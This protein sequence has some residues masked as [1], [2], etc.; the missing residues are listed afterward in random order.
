[1]NIIIKKTFFRIVSLLNIC[2]IV[3]LL[4]SN[5]APY[6][7][8]ATWWPV[9]LAGLLFPVLI[10]ATLLFFFF[11]L[12]TKPQRAV[13]SLLGILISIPNIITT[14]GVSLS[15]NFHAEKQKEDI[16]I[17]S[18]NTGLMNYTAPDS[19]TAITN[20][21]II[22]KK[23]KEINADIVCLQEFFTAVLP[24]NHYNLIDSIVKTMH[25]P[26]YYF[27]RDYSKFNGNFYSGSIIFSRYPIADTVKISY[28]KPFASSI[29][30]AGIIIAGDTIDIIT[31]RLQSVHFERNEYEELNKIK[32][33]SDSAFAGTKNIIQ[34]LRLAYRRRTEQ[35]NIVKG[36]I[37]ASKRP[38]IFTGDLNDVPVSY[39][40]A[41]VKNNLKD[42]W[43]NK[44]AGL[45]RTFVY[46][47]PTL[48]IDQLFFS[49]HFNS[50]QVKRVFAEGAS[51]HHALVADLYFKK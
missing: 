17:I 12:F 13:F 34:K 41:Q 47:S 19:N 35:V 9:A 50:R 11:W 10:I 48:R 46:L 3:L 49:N 20:N 37:T 42:A 25:Y 16:R 2:C 28:P 8:P 36:I 4:A 7:N 51:D 1:M 5:A 27:S 29:I 31:T 15:S 26:Y 22:F 14:F 45:G 39:T 18:W 30:K 38:L 24:G 6:L 40:Y 32:T 44:G 33:G 23:L 21:A 43:I